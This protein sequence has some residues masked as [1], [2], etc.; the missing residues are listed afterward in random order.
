MIAMADKMVCRGPDAEGWWAHGHAA[1]SHRRLIV[2]DPEGGQQPMVRERSGQHYVLVY[3]GE[4]YNTVELRQQLTAL[5]HEFRGHA[6]T[7]VVLEAYL[8]WGPAAVERFNGIFA[9]GL[10]DEG[11]RTLW[12]ARDRMGVK[13]LFWAV[14]GRDLIFASDLRAMLAHELIEPEVGPDGLSEIFGLGPA[15]TPG[16]GIF[17]G[18]EE[19]KPGHWLEYSTRG[20]SD[21]VYWALQSHAHEDDLPTTIHHLRNLLEDTVVRQL[22]ADVPVVTLLSGGLDS[23]IVTAMAAKAFDRA[24]RGPLDTYSIDFVDMGRYFQSNGFQTNL[25]APWVEVVSEYLGTRHHRVVLDTP[26]LVDD[27]L[28]ALHARN[29]PGMA[30]V[31]SSLLTFCREIKR[32]A[33]VALSGE[34]A[35]EIFGGYP[36]FHMEGAL[37]ATTFPWA[38]TLDRRLAVWSEELLGLTHL[39]DY[40]HDRY[41][42]ALA[43]VPRLAGEPRDQARLREIA[44]L[45]ITRFMPTLLD[46]KDR[47][48]MEVG[49]EVRVP[50][51]DHRI[52]EYA[53]NIPWPWKCLGGQSKGILRQAVADLLPPAV[54]SRQKSP[55]PSTVN[56]SYREAMRAW[57]RQTLA[58]SDSP[59][60]PCVDHEF[61]KRLIDGQNEVADIPWFGQLM[62]TP[63]LFAFLIQLDHWLRTYHVRIRG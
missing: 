18:I 19:L 58:E 36:W 59:L 52:V 28:P 12:L 13:P 60:K 32:N 10:L 54:V 43:E 63:Q 25:D 48:S 29:Y 26:E 33:T 40:V 8:E 7:E 9:I 31:D 6:D 30:D 3:N 56:P 38:R 14:R 22:V 37:R 55:Y 49:L 34:A 61:L 57:L 15:R 27:L 44:Y 50:Y 41:Q 51:C 11:R 5:G 2:V 35:D 46:R 17:Q 4:I 16:H 47:M 23:S 42:Q 24:N 20:L 53:W 39:A 62:G 1:F 21:H 45:S